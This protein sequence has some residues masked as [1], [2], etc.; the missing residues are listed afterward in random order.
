MP[1]HE[2]HVRSVIV[3]AAAQY[4]RRRPRWGSLGE[5]VMINS[6][7]EGF[8]FLRYLYQVAIAERWIYRKRIKDDVLAIFVFFKLV[9]RLSGQKLINVCPAI[10]APKYGN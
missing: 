2:A 7:D 6:T 1:N 10:S 3:I 5:V 4:L 9:L 8:V